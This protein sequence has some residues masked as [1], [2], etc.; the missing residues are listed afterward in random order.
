MRIPNPVAMFREKRRK[1]DDA[2]EIERL[3]AALRGAVEK[4]NNARPVVAV[5]ETSDMEA[6]LDHAIDVEE[7]LE[8]IHEAYM[9]QDLEALKVYV[10]FAPDDKLCTKRVLKETSEMLYRFGHR[11]LHKM[12]RSVFHNAGLI[13]KAL[14]VERKD[15]DSKMG[16][17]F[18]E[19]GDLGYALMEHA[20]LAVCARGPKPVA[21]YLLE[22]TTRA[23][24]LVGERRITDHDHLIEV[25][26]LVLTSDAPA[27]IDGML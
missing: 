24:N 11:D 6:I 5:N 3:S 9:S 4:Y 25:V 1:H 27:L 18:I 21:E 14:M 10:L 15:H 22:D 7:Q 8:I 16:K 19:G 23:M 13:Y 12:E 17:H 26:S 20:L 2:A